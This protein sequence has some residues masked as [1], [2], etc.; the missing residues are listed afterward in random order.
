MFVAQHFYIDFYTFY[1]IN[2]GSYYIRQM[3]EW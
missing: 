2:F 1:K 3:Y